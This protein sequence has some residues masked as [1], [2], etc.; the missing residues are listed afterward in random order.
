MKPLRPSISHTI[1]ALISA[2]L[3]ITGTIVMTREIAK[4]HEYRPPSQ[5][6]VSDAFQKLYEPLSIK[7]SKAVSPEVDGQAL[8]IIQSQ[9]Q[10]QLVIDSTSATDAERAV[11]QYTLAQRTR[12]LET[13]ATVRPGVKLINGQPAPANGF[14]YQVAIIFSGSDNPLEGLHC[15][16][17]LV[18]PK[19]VL[20]AAHCFN[21]GTENGDFQ[22]YLGSRK[23]SQGG[24]VISIA[25]I[26]P[27]DYDPRTNEKDIALVELSTPITNQ[28][29][30][31]LADLTTEASKATR[32]ATIS[33]WGV[34]AEGSSVASDDLQ[35]A[36]VPIIAPKVCK[37]DYSNSKLKAANR[38]DI[39]DDMICAGNGHA[40]TCQGDSGGPLVIKNR[41][42]QPYLEGIV[43]WGEGCD[44]ADF[45]G[46]YTRVPT[47]ISWINS[48]IAGDPSCKTK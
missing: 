46:V 2:C 19:W 6:A 33:G 26:L 1:T 48:C 5:A 8:A 44:L 42:N 12:Q 18:S 27:N 41:Q 9:R 23:L 35:F 31:P 7:F 21:P 34:T 24:Q 36:F 45:P 30:L 29:V 16:G 32:M 47:Y 28:T 15:G 3:A 4:R 22:V 17:T 37:T 11:A 14:Q 20:T 40:D 25:K 10:A 39:Q 43:S 38:K 13:E